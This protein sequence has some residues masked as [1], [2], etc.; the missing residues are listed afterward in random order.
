MVRGQNLTAF[1]DVLAG[2]QRL[3][4]HLPKDGLFFGAGPTGTKFGFLHDGKPK[5]RPAR[6]PAKS[7]NP[8]QAYSFI[9]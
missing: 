4:G 5:E 9:R 8:L 6:C 1:L 3:Q 2:N 7:R